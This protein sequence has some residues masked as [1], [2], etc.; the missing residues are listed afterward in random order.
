MYTLM[1]SEKTKPDNRVTGPQA[2]KQKIVANYAVFR[3]A[4]E[5]CDSANRQS[6]A[7]HYVMNDSGKEYYG[8]T[9]ID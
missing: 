6:K 4:V 8:D 2:Y 7:R 5:A 9:W 1:K 3:E